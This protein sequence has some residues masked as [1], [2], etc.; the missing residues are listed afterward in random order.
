MQ[1]AKLFPGLELGRGLQDVKQE[2]FVITLKK[3]RLVI[4]ASFDEEVDRSAGF[5]APID[6]IAKK[7]VNCALRWRV[8]EVFVDYRE[9]FLKQISAAVNVADRINSNTVRQSG[10]SKFAD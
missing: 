7:H 5:W 6:V 4:T 3:D 9:H 2:R 8:G 1:A 10:L